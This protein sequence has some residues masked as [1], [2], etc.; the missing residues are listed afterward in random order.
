MSACEMN[1]DTNELDNHLMNDESLYDVCLEMF[2]RAVYGE[3]TAQEANDELEPLIAGIA[4]DLAEIDWE[5]IAKS[6]NNID[7]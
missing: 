3:V 5:L 2:E 6:I 1:W 7:V 4:V